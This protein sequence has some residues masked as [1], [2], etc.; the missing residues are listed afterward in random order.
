MKNDDADLKPVLIIKNDN[1]EAKYCADGS[2]YLI[3][4]S[5]N[6]D[7]YIEESGKFKDHIQ[8]LNNRIK[9]MKKA[10]STLTKLKKKRGLKFKTAWWCK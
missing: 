6:Q 8:D 7:V 3:V 10:V 9:L 2:G 1:I 5:K 4:S